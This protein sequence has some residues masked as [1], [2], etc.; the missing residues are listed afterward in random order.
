MPPTPKYRC[1]HVY[2][3]IMLQVIELHEGLPIIC[4]DERGNTQLFSTAE[5][6]T[7]CVLQ[8]STGCNDQNGQEIFEG[9]FVICK[10]AHR[11]GQCGI[12]TWLEGC[13]IVRYTED[14]QGHY[15]DALAPIS[16]EL[17]KNGNLFQQKQT[18]PQLILSGSEKIRLKAAGLRA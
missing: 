5:A 6:K 12:V 15:A 4:K 17:V 1:Y 11:S 14:Y 16:S 10:S 9:D 18:E 3:E 7:L 2:K 8:Q 13:W